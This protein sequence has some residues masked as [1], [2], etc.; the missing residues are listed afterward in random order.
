MPG[1]TRTF[2]APPKPADKA[3]QA[4]ALLDGRYRI[5]RLLGEGGMGSVCLASHVGLGRQ[6]AIK[7]LHADL[8]IREEVEGRFHREAQAA[9]AIRHK[10]II[11]VFDVGMS[12][13]GEP[14]LVLAP[15]APIASQPF[16]G[17]AGR[18]SAR[19]QSAACARAGSPAGCRE[20]AAAGRKRAGEQRN[21]AIGGEREEI[22]E[23][24]A[25]R[26]YRVAS[27]Q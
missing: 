26:H 7:F 8:M 22:Q 20:R 6:G 24:G 19:S 13:K 5:D 12:P 16:T 9:A 3:A 27:A 10:N 14:F 18:I 4:D 2:L 15:P 1:K 25:A 21:P 23:E 17:C 11:E